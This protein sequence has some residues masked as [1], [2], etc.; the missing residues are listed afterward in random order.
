MFPGG[1]CTFN[2]DTSEPIFHYYT[3]DHLGNNRTVTNEDGTVE[4][5]THYYPF[6]GTFNDAGLNASLQ[7]Y[8]YN[9]KELDRVAGLNTYDYGA[10]QYFSALPVW[11][12]VDPKCEEDYGTSP[13]VYCRN[14]PVKFLDEEGMKT[15]LY[16]TTLPGGS[17]CLNMATHTFVV[18]FHNNKINYFA[19]GP[20]GKY[21]GSLRRV[22][23]E[24]DQ[25]IIKGGNK[26]HLKNMIIVKPPKG[27]T[28]DEF[29]KK[30]INEAKMFGNENNFR[31]S[32][33]P[34]KDN[35]GNCNTSSSTILYKAGV[36][37]EQLNDYRKGIRGIVT[38]FGTIK[39]WTK[40]EQKRAIKNQEFK[41]R[42]YEKAMEK[43][44]HF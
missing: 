17:S 27:M 35:E 42:I 20:Q 38:G 43:I 41:D 1:Y 12:R 31:Y 15:I 33:I 21:A 32:I 14:N 36:S 4:Q 16:A 28:E 39:A 44:S 9:G 29:D 18:V 26:E 19:Y 7:Q 24:Q 11:D 2:K 8:K 22:Y 23:Y 25:S 6:G 40:N 13:Y 3:Q 5:I 34:T 37:I 30:V 10:R